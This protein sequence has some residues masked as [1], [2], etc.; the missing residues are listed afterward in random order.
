[1]IIFWNF[2]GVPFVSLTLEPQKPQ[3]NNTIIRPTATRSCTWHRTTPRCIASQHPPTSHSTAHSSP[4]TTCTFPYIPPSYT[5]SLTRRPA[6][7]T[8]RCPKNPDSKCKCKA[9]SS[10]AGPSPNSPG[11]QSTTRPTSRLRTGTGSSRVD[12][13]NLPGSL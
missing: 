4:P 8:L 10:L 9:P 7:L 1:M 3:I 2:A 6:A 13:G 5:P 12:G 11:A